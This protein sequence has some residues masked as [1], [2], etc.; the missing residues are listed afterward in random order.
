MRPGWC[1]EDQGAVT[2]ESFAQ[3]VADCGVDPGDQVG[4][5]VG[6]LLDWS[7]E[8]H[9][10]SRCLVLLNGSLCS[11]TTKAGRRS[12]GR[13]MRAEESEDAESW[14]EYGCRATVCSACQ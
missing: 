13:R 2:M 14:V 10:G 1:R 8:R 12:A 7:K 3:F 4:R 9:G 11:A 5:E 6:G